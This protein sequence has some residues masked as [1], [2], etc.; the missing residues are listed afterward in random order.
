[1]CGRELWVREL[2]P[3]THQLKSIYSTRLISS[4]ALADDFETL[5]AWRVGI[6]IHR[7]QA[8]GPGYICRKGFPLEVRSLEVPIEFSR[9]A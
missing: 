2:S 8:F 4:D 6:R 5:H 9:V 1:M 7:R 3:R